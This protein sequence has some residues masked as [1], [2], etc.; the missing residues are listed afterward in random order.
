[1]QNVLFLLKKWKKKHTKDHVYENTDTA[2]R[3]QLAK[4]KI[5]SGQ[6]EVQMQE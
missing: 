1:M 2:L 5:F 6:Q 4:K 3:V